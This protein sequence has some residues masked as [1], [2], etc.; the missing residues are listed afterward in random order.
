MSRP[1]T[2]TSSAY[3]KRYDD[4]IRTLK[5]PEEVGYHSQALDIL[6]A[7][8]GR[9]SVADTWEMEI[10]FR[11]SREAE[12]KPIDTYRKAI[13]VR[14]YALLRVAQYREMQRTRTK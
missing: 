8:R 11:G 4:H 5:S 7:M 2:I 6:A 3:E 1:I 12:A 13:S 14:D 10:L 9:D